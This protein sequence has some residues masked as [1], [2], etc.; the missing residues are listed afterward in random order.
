MILELDP[1]ITSHALY[2]SLVESPL[3]VGALPEA[4]VFSKGYLEISEL[5]P[6]LN[7]QQKL[8]HLYEDALAYLLEVSPRVELLEK[9]LQ[10]QEN[11]QNTFG[12]LDY[13]LRDLE[14]GTLV[15]LELAVKFYLA[16]ETDDGMVFPGPDARDYY[17]RK[18]SRLREHQLVLTRKYRN[19]LPEIYQ[20]ED[21]ETQQLIYGC[22]FDHLNSEELSKP[23]FISPKCRRGRWL[24]QDELT[25]NFINGREV[26]IV[27]KPLW[28]VSLEVLQG[29]ALE[30]AELPISEPRCMM[31]MIAGELCPYFVVPNDYPV[32]N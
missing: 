17:Y 10:V 25:D 11:R 28:P 19:H 5:I 16:V 7:F 12:E 18:L 24:Y 14:S 26:S 1:H 2:R 20:R 29:I 31:V 4:D 6:E 32:R 13:L 23:D 22:L 27:P 3:L 9:N 8:G 30:Q 15:H 21:V